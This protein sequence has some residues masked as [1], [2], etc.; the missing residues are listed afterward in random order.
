[1]KT[2]TLN[3]KT[4]LS[5]ELKPELHHEIK[6]ISAINHTSIKDYV[7][8]IIIE[9]IKKDTE[10]EELPDCKY[11]PRYASL[12]DLYDRCP[13]KETV[14]CIKEAEA[15]IGLIEASSVEDLFRQLES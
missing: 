5:L 8:R 1:M 4:I 3:K 6:I 13:N 2:K 15:G 11:Q 7:T 12:E 14:Q 9:G 10:K